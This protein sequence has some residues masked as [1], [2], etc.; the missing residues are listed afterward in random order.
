[1]TRSEGHTLIYL[2]LCWL[3]WY[4][5]VAAGCMAVGPKNIHSG[6]GAHPAPSTIRN[7]ILFFGGKD[8]RGREIDLITS[9]PPSSGAWGSVV[10]KTLRY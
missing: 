10:V 9:L 5:D 3:S 6:S 1:M 2:C 8:G 4:S 7:G